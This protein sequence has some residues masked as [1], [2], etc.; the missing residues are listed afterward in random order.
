MPQWGLE[1]ASFCSRV[2]L[3]GLYCRWNVNSYFIKKKKEKSHHESGEWNVSF[4]PICFRKN[5]LSHS[6]VHTLT[7]QVQPLVILAFL[8]YNKLLCNRW[9]S[10]EAAIRESLQWIGSQSL[11]IRPS[12]DKSLLVLLF[13]LETGRFCFQIE[14]WSTIVKSFQ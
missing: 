8:C 14:F 9:H 11:Q 4:I 3:S 6:I 13:S 7:G 10:L 5:T 12:P 1:P 2:S